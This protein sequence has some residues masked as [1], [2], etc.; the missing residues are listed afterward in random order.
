MHTTSVMP[1]SIL[2]AGATGLVGRACLRRLIADPAFDRIIVPTRR[3]L[4]HEFHRTD[5]TSKID[6]HV[7][8]FDRL[9]DYPELFRAER[10]LCCLGTTIKKAGSREEFRKVDFG[11]PR[12]L[13]A[14]GAEQGARQF[15][16]VSA[17]GADPGSRI[18]YNRV[19]GEIEAAVIELSYHRVTIVRPSLLLGDRDEF[20][21]VEEIAKPFR[22]LIPGKY[23]PVHADQVATVLVGEAH[24]D[25]PG[26]QIIESDE[27]TRRGG[28]NAAI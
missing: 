8:D 3:P 15:L 7:V 9:G 5:P 1:G 24:R 13:A 11:Y 22:F 17:I 20:R 23:K 19:K 12:E 10:I 28:E 18:F 21:L 6:E 14:L 16:L 4:P 25:D 2:L 26:V 27:I